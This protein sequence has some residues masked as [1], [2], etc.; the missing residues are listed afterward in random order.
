[1][2]KDEEAPMK[3]LHSH[4][5]AVPAAGGPLTHGAGI[6]HH[7]LGPDGRAAE[8]PA[9]HVRYPIEGFVEDQRSLLAATTPSAT[10]IRTTL[11]LM[12]GRWLAVHPT[13]RFKLDAPALRESFITKY[14]QRTEPAYRSRFELVLRFLA[15][16]EFELVQNGLAHGLTPMAVR[17]EFVEYLLNYRLSAKQREIPEAAL[18]FFL[19]DWS[20]KWL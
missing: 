3:S 16:W 17:E 20:H 6:S 7:E 18:Q 12:D 11:Q 10:G 19:E 8:P 4:R 2:L 5:P 15:E 14:G 1:M 9:Q 13:L